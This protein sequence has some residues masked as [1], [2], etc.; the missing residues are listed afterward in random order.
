MTRRFTFLAVASLVA[1]AVVATGAAPSEA[2]RRSFEPG[3]DG[4]GDPYYPQDGNG[5]YDVA[6]YGLSIVVDP[7]TRALTGV[8][9]IRAKAT[10]DLSAFNLDLDGLTVRSV[11]VAGA[12]AAWSRSSGELTVTPRVRLVRGAVVQDGR[13]V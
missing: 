7:E 12:A 10:Q 4:V 1:T 2:G 11:R 9:R 13:P 8:A 3:S 6:H 5:G